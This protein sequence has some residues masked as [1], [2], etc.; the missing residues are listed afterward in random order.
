MIGLF[1]WLL[2][3]VNLELM[4]KLAAIGIVSEVKNVK[5][6]KMFLCQDVARILE[7]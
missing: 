1:Y 5:R 2:V 7:S 3:T 4:E 6:P